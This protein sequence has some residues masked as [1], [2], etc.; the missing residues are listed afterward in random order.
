M[1]G[2]NMNNSPLYKYEGFIY[3]TI[4]FVFILIIIIY[5][6]LSSKLYFLL[7]VFL[8]LVLIGLIYSLLKEEIYVVKFYNSQ[9]DY[10]GIFKSFTIPYQE[11]FK[12]EIQS[13]GGEV[14]MSL[15]FAQS[16]KLKKINFRAIDSFHFRRIKKIL[17]QKNVKVIDESG[18]C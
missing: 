3:A 14:K 12:V 11:I 6:I 9:I 17:E 2:E 5:F 1:K 4:L 16:D 8:I 7:K 13:H 18:L 15:Y 10:K